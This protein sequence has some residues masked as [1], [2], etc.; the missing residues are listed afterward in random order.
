MT[1]RKDVAL[2]RPSIAGYRQQMLEILIQRLGGD[3]GFYAGEQDFEPT[4]RTGV[5]LD[6]HLVTVEN[7]YL[8]G[9]R[10]LWQAGALRSLVG[11]EVTVLE[12]NPRVLSSWAAILARKLRG[13][14][15]VLWGHAFPRAGRGTRTDLLRGVLRG[16]A[17]V[18]VVYTETECRELR[19]LYPRRVVIAAPNGLYPEARIGAA[20]PPKGPGA[21]VYVGRLIPA[22]KPGLLLDAFFAA[23]SRLPSGIRLVFVGDGPLRA[24]LEAAAYQSEDVE[25]LGEVTQYERLRDL[26]AEAICSV[27]PGYVGLS[28]V[29]SLSFGVPMIVARDEPHAPEVEAAQEG[30]NSA[31][32]ESDSPE[33]L[34]DEL[35]RFA[36][37]QDAWLERRSA[38]AGDCARRYSAEATAAGLQRAIEAAQR[39]TS[40]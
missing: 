6:G 4:T 35:I 12:L 26:Y 11:A 32:V 24:S 34:A 36:A 28:I 3:I 23:R 15:T 5:R 22:K 1:E 18:V 33:A 2:A 17:D 21:F 16:L 20:A 29:Q 40:N 30:A 9:R 19:Q 14:P 10:L 8:L 37:E 27:S 31:F 13:K 39:L 38:I 7:N 25:F